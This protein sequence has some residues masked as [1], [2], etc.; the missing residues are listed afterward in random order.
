[1]VYTKKTPPYSDQDKYDGTHEVDWWRY[2][3]GLMYE[4]ILDT[5]E[6]YKTREGVHGSELLSGVQRYLNKSITG[7]SSSPSITN[8]AGGE[9][10]DMRPGRLVWKYCYTY[11]HS[12][13]SKID[14]Y[15]AACAKVINANA[16]QDDFRVGYSDGHKDFPWQHKDNYTQQVWLDG[17]FMGIPYWTLAG[18]QIGSSQKSDWGTNATK[19]FDDAVRQMQ[20]TDST[21]FVPTTG[22]WCHAWDYTK[23][24]TWADCSNL[25]LNYP[26]ITAETTS[27]N[28]TGRSLHTWG[29]ALGWYAMAIM[30]TMDNIT[31]VDANYAKLNDMKALFKK[32]MDAVISYRD[33]TSG[34]W[35]CVLDVGDNTSAT[36]P[37]NPD[38]YPVDKK[39]KRNNY[40]EATCSSMFAYCLL[41]GVAKGYLD[42]SYLETAK[43]AYIKVVSNFI[44]TSGDEIHLKNCMQV[45]GL[46]SS[47]DGSFAYYMS[48]PVILDDSKGVGPFIWASLEAEKIGYNME[49][50]S[51][52]PVGENTIVSFAWSKASDE[53]TQGSTYSSPTFTARSY[54]NDTPLTNSSEI[55][56][57]SSNPAVATVA[58]DGTVTPVG[59]GTATITASLKEGSTYIWSGTNPS[60]T[61][62]VNMP[63]AELA[64][65]TT[66]ITKEIGDNAF[67][68]T[69]TNPNNVT[70]SYS[71]TNNGT[72]STINTS[73]G[74]V[75][76]GSNAG[77][78]TITASFA[79][80][81]IYGAQDVTYTLTVSAA[82]P[83]FPQGTTVNFTRSGSSN[84]NVPK[85]T[86]IGS[87]VEMCSTNNSTNSSTELQDGCLKLNTNNDY[88]HIKVSENSK[89]TI[90]AKVGTAGEKM[91]VGTDAT[92]STAN[93]S[94]TTSYADYDFTSTD[95]GDYYIKRVGK[96]LYIK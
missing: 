51:F 86:I 30:E 20:V 39:P 58:A 53:I 15:K 75:S 13:D 35:Y 92:S 11:D 28:N 84:Q 73:T 80:N 83:T 33:E 36:S 24:K 74:E 89:I 70:V 81:S 76:I 34:V 6:Y 79:G 78:E 67:T 64:Y 43:D 50:N 57:V 63:S 95:G 69:L 93:T 16:F 1:M 5:Y 26:H 82:F 17:I 61:I 91:Y 22:L 40:L 96:S 55:D 85:E 42:N 37:Y 23:T 45:G 48:E 52:D 46:D 8:F 10:D 90:N 21:T 2:D 12:E 54:G 3:D 60:Y 27:G 19:F 38:N 77:T 29:R 87:Y 7:S 41:H 9:L 71:I 44:T 72:G 18:P 65:A 59:V 32:V 94:V 62:T 25:S 88:L 66:S 4:S 47:R 14:V 49:N 31:A 56:F 68:N